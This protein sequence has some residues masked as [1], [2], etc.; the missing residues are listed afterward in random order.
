MMTFS[1]FILILLNGNLLLKGHY[2]KEQLM[3]RYSGRGRTNMRL[4][5]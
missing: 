5:I 2:F 4:N 3:A 1:N